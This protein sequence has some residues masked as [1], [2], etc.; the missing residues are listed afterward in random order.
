MS[1]FDTIK[2]FPYNKN[3]SLVFIILLQETI[4]KIC[5][6]FCMSIENKL[7]QIYLMFFGFIKCHIAFNIHS[8]L[9]EKILTPFH[10]NHTQILIQCIPIL[11]IQ[12]VNKSIPPFHARNL[13]PQS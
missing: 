12:N 5:T 1:P 9:T 6:T 10:S 3:L 13:F 11:L 4:L 2:I 7:L 8:N